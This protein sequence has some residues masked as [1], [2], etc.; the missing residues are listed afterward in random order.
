MSWQPIKT[1]PRDVFVLVYEQGWNLTTN[2]CDI[3]QHEAEDVWE[4]SEGFRNMHPTHWMP[5]P[6]APEKAPT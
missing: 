5:L 6:T 4:T 3:A 2:D 1:A